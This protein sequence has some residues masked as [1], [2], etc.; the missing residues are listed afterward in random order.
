M[1]ALPKPKGKLFDQEALWVDSLIMAILAKSFTK[2]FLPGQEEEAFV[3]ALL[4]D[5]ALP[6]LLLSWEEYYSPI[7]D[8]WQ[9]RSERLS[10]IERK[11][12]GWDHGQAGAWIVKSWNFSE[13]MI[14]YIGAHNLTY[15]GLKDYKLEDTIALPI[16]LSSMAPSVLKPDPERSDTFVNTTIQVLRITPSDLIEAVKEVK[17]S[18]HEV[19]KLFE[20]PVRNSD[21]I[22]YD[23]TQATED[24]GEL[25]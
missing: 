16:A 10:E 13:E 9:S 24:K 2:R 15:E 22:F 1:D 8:E 17:E 7:I 14:C 12:F 3:S 5:L 4:S 25:S 21:Q 19:R 18:F 20:L 6:V 11:H 23:L